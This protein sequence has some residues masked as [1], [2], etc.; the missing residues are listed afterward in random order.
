M[1]IPGMQKKTSQ[2]FF[3]L[4]I[5]AFEV[6]VLNIP[7]YCER[8]LVIRCH[9]DN[10]QSQDFRYHQNKFFGADFRSELL[11]KMT[12]LLLCRFKKIFGH[13]KML[14][15]HMCSDTGLFTHLSDP[16]FCSLQFHQEI[17]SE[18]HLLIHSI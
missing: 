12:K 17:A 7:F 5:I 3:N 2:M 1:E 4:E 11:K 15:V 16:A 10:N 9:Y 8:I 14:H 13:F 6:V 18:V